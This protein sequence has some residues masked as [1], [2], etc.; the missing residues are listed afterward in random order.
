MS[1]GIAATFVSNAYSRLHAW[2]LGQEGN[3]SPATLAIAAGCWFV[4]HNDGNWTHLARNESSHP[5]TGAAFQTAASAGYPSAW[6]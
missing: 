6:P 2:N 1:D 4:W 3:P 5:Q